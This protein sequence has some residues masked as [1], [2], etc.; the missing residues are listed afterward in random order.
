MSAA[1]D[2]IS[3]PRAIDPRPLEEERE[4]SPLNAAEGMMNALFIV[5]LLGLAFLAWKIFL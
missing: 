4:S 2:R 3:K 5:F 1:S